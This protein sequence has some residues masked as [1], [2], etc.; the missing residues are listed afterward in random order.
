MPTDIHDNRLLATLIV[1]QMFA[2]G[3]LKY[4][5][6][7]MRDHAHECSQYLLREIERIERTLI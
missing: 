5:P 1:R 3:E 2:D 4:K 7:D 6:N